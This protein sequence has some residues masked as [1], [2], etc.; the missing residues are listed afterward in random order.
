MAHPPS[1]C[2][3]NDIADRGRARTPDDD[4]PKLLRNQ[5]EQFIDGLADPLQPVRLRDGQV[6]HE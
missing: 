4:W 6:R 5:V 3:E 2:R 1:G